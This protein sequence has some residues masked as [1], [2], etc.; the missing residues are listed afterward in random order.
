M[1]LEL[2][3]RRIAERLD[4]AYANLPPLSRAEYEHMQQLAACYAVGDG[5]AA[6][7]EGAQASGLQ[8]RYRLRSAAFSIPDR[9][10]AAIARPLGADRTNNLLVALAVAGE[11]QDAL[12]VYPGAAADPSYESPLTMMLVGA[13]LQQAI[14]CDSADL[15]AGRRTGAVYDPAAPVPAGP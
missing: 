4:Q 6:E 3:A 8:D 12:E 1:P 10:D 9:V 14:V 7:F 5:C 2:R 15:A 13:D 11:A